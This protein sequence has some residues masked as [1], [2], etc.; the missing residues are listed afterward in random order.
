MKKTYFLCTT[1]LLSVLSVFFSCS[2]DESVNYTPISPVVVDIENIPYPKLS[3]YKFFTGEI[4]NLEPAIG[5][6]PY[7]LSSPLFTDYAHKKR[8]VWMPEGVSATYDADNT[9]LNFPTGAV[10]IKNFYYD[11]IQPGNSTRVIETRLMIKKAEGWTFANYIWNE[12]QTEALLNMNG[13]YTDITWTQRGEDMA[14]SY[15]IPSRN[16]CFTCHKSGNDTLPIGPKPQNLNKLFTYNDGTVNQLTK[17]KQA[18]YLNTV[19]NNVNS[20]VDWTDTSQP[21]ELRVRS[22]LDINCAHCHSEGAHCD[23]RPIKL[24]FS[25]TSNP[26]NLGICIQP[27]EFLNGSQTHIIASGSA[28]RSVL[29]YRMNTNNESQRMPLLGRTIVHTEAVTL[30][31]EWIDAMEEPC[32]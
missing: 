31:T 25:E 13:G 5:V 23:Y 28:Q 4:K 21:M 12:S 14:T 22:Y 16:E 3:D 7:D 10:L 27:H 11:S 18:G 30:I 29:P 8:F 26:I 32:P 19:P 9:V 24:A 15:R 17:W 6:L 20:V 1:L 2:D